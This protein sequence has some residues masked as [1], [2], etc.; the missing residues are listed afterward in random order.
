MGEIGESGLVGVRRGLVVDGWRERGGGG[1]RL[2]SFVFG[3]NIR[4][5]VFEAY[6]WGE[7]LGTFS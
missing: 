7:S 2:G 3:G 1:G 5:Y 6:S 4:R